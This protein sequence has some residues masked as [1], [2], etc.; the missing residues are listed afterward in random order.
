MIT[1]LWYAILIFVALVLQVTLLPAYLADPFK[2]NLL[3]LFVVYLGLRENIAWG[4][5]A[6]FLGLVHDSFSGLY[7]GLNGFSYL[8][9]FWL[10]TTVADRL[11]TD[12]RSLMVVG[13]FSA[14]VVNGFLNLLLLLLFSAAQGIYASLLQSIVP[15]GLVN[16]LVASLVFTFTPLARMGES[17]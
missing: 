9:I 7:L 15:Q 6:F 17:R 5:L 10:L 13:V 4:A 1:F 14:T 8:F 3:I 12:R 16:A 2:P 11:Y